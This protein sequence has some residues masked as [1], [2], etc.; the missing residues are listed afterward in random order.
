MKW[1]PLC[2]SDIE[3]ILFYVNFSYLLIAK[4]GIPI[5]YFTF[6]G[7]LGT[8]IFKNYLGSSFKNEQIPVP[9][10]L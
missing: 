8:N 9:T 10:F 7:V 4:V 2:Y 3:Q 6:P 1:L 5:L